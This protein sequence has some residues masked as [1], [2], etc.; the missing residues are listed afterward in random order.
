[1]QT[2]PY[3]LYPALDTFESSMIKVDD[4]HEVYYEVC[5]NPDGAPVVFLHGGPGS[6][7]NPTQRRFFDPL[8]YKI[9]LIDQR[10][11]GRS[12]PLGETTNNTIDDL[13]HDIDLIRIALGIDQWLVFGGSWG[14]TLG[15]AY[16]LKHTQHVTGLILRGIFLSRKSELD[17]FLNDVKAFYPEPWKVLCDFLPVES[18]NKPIDAYQQMIFSDDIAISIPAAI[19]WNQFESSIMTLLPRPDSDQEVNGAVEL[20]RARVQIHYIHHEC[21]IGGRD[22]LAEARDK[23]AEVPTVIVQ[24]R[25]DM[26]C[27]PITA[28]ELK[29]AMPHAEFSLIDDAGHSAMEPGTTSALIAATEKFKHLR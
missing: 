10:G 9:I 26:V 23:L 16:A 21:F 8:H 12:K 13:V 24:G 14:S 15:I 4:I 6:G 5:G 19:Q 3:N 11:C 7:C 28:W 18:R 20:A 27:P 2:Y 25:Y 1:M 22:L 17:W 29:R